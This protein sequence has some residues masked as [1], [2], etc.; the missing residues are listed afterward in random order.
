ME[1]IRI[2]TTLQAGPNRQIIATARGHKICMDVRKEWGGDDAGTT[3]PECM[4]IGLGGCV[5]NIARIIAREKEIDLDTIGITVSGDIDPSRAFGLETETRAG[6]TRM[7]V[8]VE[9]SP[10]LSESMRQEFC[11]EL[12]ERCPLCDTIGNPT[13]LQIHM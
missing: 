9:M 8:Q 5:M 1:E 4:A 2:V 13:P 6:F 12:T 7:S 11:R 10:R 3:P